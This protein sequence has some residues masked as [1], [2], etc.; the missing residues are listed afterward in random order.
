MNKG[1]K[2]HRGNAETRFPYHSIPPGFAFIEECLCRCTT[3]FR[4]EAFM[5]FLKTYSIEGIVNVTGETFDDS[6]VSFAD[7]N[8][9]SIVSYT[10]LHYEIHAYII[11]C[12]P[13]HCPFLHATLSCHTLIS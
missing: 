9:I 12:S 3:P 5:K 8:G 4:N 6:L 7:E 1:R 11:Y 13:Q 2:A 10:C